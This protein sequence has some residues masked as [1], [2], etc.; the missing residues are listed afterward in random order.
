MKRN[1]SKSVFSIFGALF[2]ALMVA[3][4]ANLPSGG[5]EGGGSPTNVKP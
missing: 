1:E 2:L 3:G 4:C 5:G